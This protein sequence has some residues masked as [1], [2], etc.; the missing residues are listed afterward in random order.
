LFFERWSEN[1][2]DSKLGRNNDWE[3]ILFCLLAKTGL[4]TNGDVFFKIKAFPFQSGK[5]AMSRRV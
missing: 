4:N 2:C 5:K 1:L 3:A